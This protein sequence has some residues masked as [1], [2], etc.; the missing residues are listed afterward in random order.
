MSKV[1]HNHVKSHKI[2]AEL[3]MLGNPMEMHLQEFISHPY[4]GGR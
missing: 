1:G 2:E 3:L 4:H